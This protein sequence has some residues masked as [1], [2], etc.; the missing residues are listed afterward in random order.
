MMVRIP[1]L[2][3]DKL[4]RSLQDLLTR[5]KE[6]IRTLESVIGLMAFYARAIPSARAFLRRF[7]DLL[8]AVKVR[9]PFY[10]IRIAEEVK[11]DITVWLQFLEDFNGE[12]YIL[13]NFWLTN[14]ALELFT[15]STGNQYLGCGAYFKGHWL[16][17]RWPESWVGTEIMRDITFLE[18]VPIVLAL[19]SWH[20]QFNNKKIIFRIDNKALVTI[21]NKRTSKSKSVMKLI[22]SLVLCTLRSNIHF[23]AI[24]IAGSV[25]SVADALSRFQMKRFRDLAPNADQHPTR[26]PTE[27]LSIISKMI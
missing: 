25:N 21:I 20:S 12:C 27:F 15:D 17:F 22:R 13:E 19:L 14:E 23:K 11:Y 7:Y 8:S 6:K 24:H 9:K 3:L 5:K 2:K 4:K 26:I 10:K 1:A 16:Q 18:L